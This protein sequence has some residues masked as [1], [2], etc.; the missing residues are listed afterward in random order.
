MMC[1]MTVDVAFVR[2]R[3]PYICFCDLRKTENHT[4]VVDMS[5]FCNSSLKRRC[6]G[7]KRTSYAEYMRTLTAC[8]KEYFTQK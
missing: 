2:K 3:A 4:G 5:M 7:S 1:E 8:L 6:G